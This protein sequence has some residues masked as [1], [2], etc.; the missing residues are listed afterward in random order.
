MLEYFSSAT[1]IGMTATP[2]VKEGANNLDYFN[3]PLYTYS[4]KQGIEDGF[5]APY[6][7]TNSFLNIDLEGWTPE[8][9]ELDIKV[10]SLKLVFITG[11]HLDVS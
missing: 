7:V 3:E 5:L 11:K 6:R 10:I 9:D 1:Q 8:E 2:K 4:L